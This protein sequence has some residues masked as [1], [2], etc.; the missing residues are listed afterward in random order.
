VP[1]DAHS[2]DD[3]VFAP[4]GGSNGRRNTGV[5]PGND[6]II[7]LLLVMLNLL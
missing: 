7:R 5:P 1:P 2:L 3:K 6:H 4:F